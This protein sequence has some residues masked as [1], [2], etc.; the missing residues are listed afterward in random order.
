MK[1]SRKESSR[2]KERGERLA[3]ALKA[4]IKRRKNQARARGEKQA[5]AEAGQKEA[6]KP[7]GDTP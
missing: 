3:I 4:N 2:K 7:P 5:P 6:G 1:G